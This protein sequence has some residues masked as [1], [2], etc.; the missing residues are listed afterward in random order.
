MTRKFDNI[1]PE[2]D[3]VKDDDEVIYCTGQPKLVPFLA[4]GIPFLIFGLFWG[5]FDYFFFM[6]S[7]IFGGMQTFIILFMLLH[8]FPFYGSILNMIRLVLV[9]HN[10]VYAYTSK[11]LMLRSGF[12]GIDFKAIDY[13]KI[14][15]LEVNVN[16]LEKMFNVGTVRAF[17]GEFVNT[18]NGSRPVF[19]E[20]TS[21]QDPYEVFKQIKQ[22]S[23]DIKTDWNY[24]NQLRPEDNPGYSTNYKPKK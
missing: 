12:F 21:I 24:P 19:S 9:H 11:R 5:A 6:Q 7:F 3:A 8:M 2:F 18:K 13:D 14:Q 16:P 1:P 15:N 22:I 4:R 10:T 20:F 23:V 17:T